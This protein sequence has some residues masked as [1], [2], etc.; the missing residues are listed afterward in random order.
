LCSE[1]VIIRGPKQW[2]AKIFSGKDEI[3]EI[4]K[5][6][7]LDF[8]LV[9][10]NDGFEWVLTNKV[11]GEYRPFSFAVRKS[12]KKAKVPMTMAMTINKEKRYLPS[13][14]SF[15]STTANFICLPT[16][17]RTRLGMSMFMVQS[18]TSEG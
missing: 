5:G 7:G 16:I 18:N 9:R 2:E 17:L 12:R 15:S 11:E 6:E 4:R 1:F 3:A 13:V 10:Q 14:I 8:K